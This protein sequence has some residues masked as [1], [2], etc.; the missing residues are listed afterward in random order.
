MNLRSHRW[1]ACFA[2]VTAA[3]GEFLAVAQVSKPAG[4][5]LDGLV[6]EKRYPELER[7]VPLA[8]LNPA[9]HAYFVGVLADLTNHPSE[10][11]AALKPILPKLLSSDPKRAA[12]ALRTLADA[13]FMT[14]QYGEASD[15]YSDVLRKF[16]HEFSRAERESITDNRN[17]FELLRGAAPQTISGQRDFSVAIHDNV[18]GD[19]EVPVQIRNRTEWWILDTGANTSAITVSTAKR[20]GLTVSKRRASSQGSTGKEVSLQTAVIPMLNV[21]TAELS[22]VIAVVSD[23]KDFNVPLGKGKRFQIEGVL[24]Y[25]V[26]AA[27]G[28]LQITGNQLEV[29]PESQDSKRCTRLYVDQLTP[30]MEGTVDDHELLF[31]LDTG[32]DAVAFTRKYLRQFPDQFSSL[33]AHKYGTGG[34]GGIRF[35]QAYYLPQVDLHLSSATA[36]LNNVPVMTEDMGV[37]PLDSI[38]GNLGQAFLRNFRS[39]T[40][41][42]KYMRICVGANRSE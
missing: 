17:L 4:S 23:D 26:L 32:A 16:A 12:I 34:I 21:G 19:V 13:Y 33:K 39:Y 9:E 35:M 38:Y 6:A 8:D 1:L 3:F 31:Q 18:L 24:G 14:G 15:A 5:V 11:I 40:L 10:A 25:P 37:D 7:Q 27:L 42:F 22:N 20:L 28:S 2:L 30:L 36:T 29:H 41:D